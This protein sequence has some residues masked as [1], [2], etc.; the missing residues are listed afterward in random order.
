MRRL[1]L[2]DKV[3]RVRDE[4][5]PPPARPAPLVCVHGAGGSS[6]SFMDLVRRL[7]VHRRVIAPDLPGHGQSDRWHETIT[8]DGYREAVGTVCA[9]L[10]VKRAVILGHS[11][12]AAVALR[13]ALSWPERVAGL[14]LVSGGAA[15]RVS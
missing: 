7:A 6:V 2:G 5:E 9:H 12:G 15:L 11:M 1:R 10:G 13:C 3:L 14:V 4:P 8:I